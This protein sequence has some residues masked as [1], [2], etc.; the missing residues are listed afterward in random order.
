METTTFSKRKK[1]YKVGVKKTLQLL[2]WAWV[3]LAIWAGAE[4]LT[5]VLFKWI[6]PQN[7]VFWI[8]S[9]AEDCVALFFVIK[10][11]QSFPYRRA[12]YVRLKT[13][14]ERHPDKIKKSILYQMQEAPCTKESA[15]LLCDEFNITL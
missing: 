13:I 4:L 11:S 5:V 6:Y 14:W 7:L 2:K 8:L 15:D 9:V 1:K 12:Q 3:T 10:V